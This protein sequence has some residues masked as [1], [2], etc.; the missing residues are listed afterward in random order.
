MLKQ[1]LAFQML[2]EKHTSFSSEKHTS[3]SSI[4]TDEHLFEGYFVNISNYTRSSM[5]EKIINNQQG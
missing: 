1:M 5:F 4:R 2:V 3:F